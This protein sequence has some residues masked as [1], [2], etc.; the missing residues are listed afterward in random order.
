MT[1]PEPIDLTQFD[2][3]FVNAE[4]EERT[5]ESVP[6]GKYQVNVERVELKHTKK[7]GAPML[8]WKLKIIGPQCV[9]RVLWRN[10][11]MA[12]PDNIKW[13]KNDLHT[14]G[15]DLDKLSDLPSRL[16]DLLDVKLN[17][18]VRSVEENTNVYFDRRIV[19]GEQPEPADANELKPF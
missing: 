11:V 18:T 15:L 6:D 3:H 1:N 5:F 7:T 8:A 16:E 9:G 14:C 4:I 10:N 13:L 19:G 2:D 12:S 17:V